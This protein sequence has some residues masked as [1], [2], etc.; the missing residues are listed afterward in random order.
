MLSWLHLFTQHAMYSILNPGD[1]WEKEA[2]EECEKADIILKWQ[3]QNSN[4]EDMAFFLLCATASCNREHRQNSAACLHPQSPHAYFS[5]HSQEKHRSRA[6]K[7]HGA[8]QFSW[9]CSRLG[10]KAPVP[11]W[12]QVFIYGFC[13]CLPIW[14]GSSSLETTQTFI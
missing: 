9:R 2:Q 1:Q 10:I 5:V 13:Y 4:L 8:F 7:P 3:G 14:T 12:N 11:R 6:P